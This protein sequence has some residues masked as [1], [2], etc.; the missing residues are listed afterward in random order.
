MHWSLKRGS[1]AELGSNANFPWSKGVETRC[2]GGM[3]KMYSYQLRTER[4]GLLGV[5]CTISSQALNI[6]MINR[7]FLVLQRIWPNFPGI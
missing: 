2:G 3:V 5:V 7:S 6:L 1:K 4:C